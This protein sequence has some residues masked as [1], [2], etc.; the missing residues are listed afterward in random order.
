MK[1]SRITVCVYSTVM[2]KLSYIFIV[3]Y[4]PQCWRLS[5]PLSQ[6]VFHVK[7]KALFICSLQ[8][9]LEG[10]RGGRGAVVFEISTMY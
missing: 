1:Y 2:T 3:V 10:E 7:G 8:E 9:F 5:F 6:S 4:Y